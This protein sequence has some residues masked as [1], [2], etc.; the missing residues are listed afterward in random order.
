MNEYSAFNKAAA[1]LSPHNQIIQSHTQDTS[2]VESYPSAEMQSVYSTDPGDWGDKKE[3][4]LFLIFSR[5]PSK[6]S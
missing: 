3:R 1:L 6:I 5:C 2:W 4:N